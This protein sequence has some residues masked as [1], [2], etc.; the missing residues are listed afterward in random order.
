MNIPAVLAN[1]AWR[2][3]TIPDARRFN[4]AI[5]DVET[6]QRE[7]LAELLRGNSD[8]VYGRQFDFANIKS[9]EQYQAE[10]PLIEYSDIE[11]YISQM[12]DGAP[13]ILFPGLPT[14]FVPTSGTTHGTKLIPYNAALRG[15]FQAGIAPWIDDMFRHHP[16]LTGGQAYWSISPAT[17]ENR[18]TNGGIPI[19][20]DDDTEYLHPLAAK[21]LGHAM[22][23]PAIVSRINDMDAFRYATL[24]FLLRAHDLRFISGWNP[25]FLTLLLAPLDAWAERLARDIADGTLI[26]PA[27]IPP[28][29]LAKLQSRLSPLPS[30]ARAI[31]QALSRSN[32]SECMA[33]LWP[34]LA[35][36]SCWTSAAASYPAQELQRLFPHV[37]IAGK[38]LLS[39]EGFISLPLTGLPGSALSIRSHFFEFI[40][41]DDNR[42]YTT[43][44][45]EK[46]VEYQAIITT[47]GGLYRYRTGDIV[48]ITGHAGNCPLLEFT[49]RANAVS[50]YYG[51]KI[52]ESHAAHAIQQAAS[53]TGIKLSFALLAPEGNPQP[54]NYT[55]FAVSDLPVDDLFLDDFKCALESTL[56]ENIHY[57][58]CRQ[59]GQLQQAQVCL[60]TISATTAEAC[61]IKNRLSQGQRAGDIK[62]VS[63]DK[64]TGWRERFNDV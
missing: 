42:I 40:P 13:D 36:I 32:R 41:L 43:W 5:T 60:L 25:T 47:G 33:Q 19:G 11:S 37:E 21:M 26:P 45:L 12:A 54:T 44:Q 6:T 51:E 63:L 52:H 3:S 53:E 7:K 57:R 9:V 1:I 22:A 62:P 38:G 50:D 49:G 4:H 18:L 34:R 24:L 28:D 48:E 23:V 61:W 46:D 10:V 64:D 16:A 31:E 58:Y 2:L 56:C 29:V 8:T 39:T 27:E 30:R 55:L 15:E 17:H 59:L 14:S 20:F 35:L